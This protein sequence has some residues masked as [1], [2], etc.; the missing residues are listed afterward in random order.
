MDIT[1]IGLHVRRK[2]FVSHATFPNS[3]QLLDAAKVGLMVES[4]RLIPV[5]FHLDI[6]TSK[7][8]GYQGTIENTLY[9]RVILFLDVP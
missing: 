6:S 7:V 8:E 9:V 3:V 1:I 5:L 4:K 2:F